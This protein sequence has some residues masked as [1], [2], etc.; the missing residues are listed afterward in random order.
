MQT[1]STVS[2]V[3]TH[4]HQPHLGPISTSVYGIRGMAPH[5][6]LYNAVYLQEFSLRQA[7]ANL[8]HFK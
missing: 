7:R 4:F 5:D 2:A 3:H 8:H 6:V 1:N